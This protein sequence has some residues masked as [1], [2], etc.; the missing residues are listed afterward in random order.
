MTTQQDLGV[1]NVIW[2]LSDLY[3]NHT[4]GSFLSDLEGLEQR[5]LRL[6]ETWRGRLGTIDASHMA[7]FASEYA[8]VY[9]TADRLGSYTHLLW[10]TD[11]LN[12]EYGR[13]LQ[14][15]RE[16]V[17]TAFSHLAFISVELASIPE[18]RVNAIASAPDM[19][20]YRH[21]FESINI[22]RPHV[23]SEEV[24]RVLSQTSLTGHAA[25]VRLH[26]EVQ[27]RQSYNVDGEV[28]TEA[29]ILKRLHN[30]DREVRRRAA[31][32]FSAGIEAIVPIQ[33]YVYNTILA[34][35]ALHDRLRHHATWIE[36]RNQSNEAQSETVN[37][38]INS[39]TS[40]YDL[41]H[42]VYALKQRLLGY[43]TFYDY[44]RYAPVGQKSDEVWTWQQAKDLVVESYSAFH[45]KAGEIA[46]MFFERNWIHAPVQK[47]KSGGAYSAGTVAS[48]HPYVF[49]NYTGTSRDVQVLAHELGHGIHQYLSR[50][51]GQL[52]MDTPLTVAETAS[53]FGE[54]LVFRT[55]LERTASTQERL[56]LLMSKIDDTMSTVM[57]QI[58][59]NRFEDA[60][61]TARRTEGELTVERFG[62]LWLETQRACLGPGVVLSPG[63]EHW[64]SYISHF[65]H[66][67][68]YVYAYAFGELLVLALYERYQRQPEGFPELYI[69]LLSA[70]GSKKPED[71]LAPLGIDINAPDFWHGGL[72]MI[73][74]LIVEA[75][76]IAG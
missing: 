47:G 15:V 60:A 37:N 3:P 10:S 54:M 66:T 29:E 19:T 52:Q 39:V 45:P 57:R 50:G 24:E 7:T 68:G 76:A 72:A 75:E 41:L 73:E 43:E 27:N 59:L 25:W 67:P 58:A 32:V 31:E 62:E 38:L 44:D 2:D 16:T 30:P 9:E 35:H 6:A 74:A 40:R 20:P 8:K 22:T 36:A 56:A 46:N 11:T 12:P 63:Y 18:D 4:N 69:D 33:A 70:G 34:D 53:V 28:L 48:V 71:L 17:S 65:V 14:R 5:A 55:L 23:L 64:W 13:L 61:H 21:W 26:D 1:H 42:R 51:V 49:M